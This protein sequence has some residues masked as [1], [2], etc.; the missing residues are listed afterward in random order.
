[1]QLPLFLPGSILFFPDLLDVFELLGLSIHDSIAFLGTHDNLGIRTF[2][3]CCC[4]TR[5]LD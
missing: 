1:M 5:T 3:I 2:D 4:T